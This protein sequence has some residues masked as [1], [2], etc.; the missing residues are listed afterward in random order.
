MAR[1]AAQ[2]ALRKEW[3]MRRFK[4]LYFVGALALVSVLAFVGVSSAHHGVQP[5]SITFTETGKTTTK[6]AVGT[7]DIRLGPAIDD[8]ATSDP[9][10]PKPT[11]VFVDLSQGVTVDGSKFPTCTQAQLENAEPA[12]AQAACGNTAPKTKNALIATGDAKAQVGTT[13]LDAT[14]LAFNGPS[15]S[16]LVYS[17]VEALSLTTI[18]PCQL[19]AAP[20][21]SLY[22][23]RF[24]CA[25]PPLAGGA[26]A[27]TVFN[28]KFDRVE[29]KVVK[30]HGKKKKKF[31]SIVF[32]KCPSSGQ[33]NFQVTWEYSDHET[34]SR[35]IT[36]AC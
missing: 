7:L 5:A 35:Q 6:G 1:E 22:K 10:P 8:P 12:A 11:N 36:Q 15:G 33:Y 16:V 30:K 19:G 4:R 20:D 27:L 24:S 18:V 21:Q 23:T 9:V 34:E 26:G 13:T 14:A 17:R 29:K 32:G 25:V 2:N 3:F 28:L 31:Y